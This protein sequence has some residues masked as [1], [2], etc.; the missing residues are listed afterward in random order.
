MVSDSGSK[1]VRAVVALPPDTVYGATTELHWC[2]LA[3][4]AA[5]VRGVVLPGDSAVRLLL[6]AT[7]NGYGEGVHHPSLRPARRPSFETGEA[8]DVAEAGRPYGQVIPPRIHCVLQLRQ[9][10]RISPSMGSPHS[11]STALASPP[12]SRSPEQHRLH[13][14]SERI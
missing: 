5:V 6:P 2:G 3:L 11:F 14:P 10:I 1:C 13:T 8:D 12:L 7:P 9:T 4:D